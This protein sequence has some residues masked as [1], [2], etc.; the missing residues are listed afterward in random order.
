VVKDE[1]F[2]MCSN[3]KYINLYRQEK[4][5]KRIEMEKAVKHLDAFCSQDRITAVA[6]LEDGE[7]RLIEFEI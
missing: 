7:G 4:L 2:I 6:T 1:L 3:E 5:F